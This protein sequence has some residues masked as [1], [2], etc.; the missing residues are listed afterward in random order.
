M[1]KV[2]VSILVAEIVDCDN[3]LVL[4]GWRS[5]ALQRRIF[6]SRAGLAPMIIFIATRRS[7]LGSRALYTTPI[8]PRPM[9]LRISY[10]PIFVG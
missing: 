4:A 6:F 1:T 7:S 8:P 5:S 3:I 9:V 2:R 10:L